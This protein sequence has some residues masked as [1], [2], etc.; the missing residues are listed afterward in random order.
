MPASVACASTGAG[1]AAPPSRT[2]SS[3]ASASIAARSPSALTNC[4]GTKEV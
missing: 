2:A 3:D 1:V 4:V